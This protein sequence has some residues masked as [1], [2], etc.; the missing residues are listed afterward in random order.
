D[1]CS[2]LDGFLRGDHGFLVRVHELV[3][4]TLAA[5]EQRVNRLRNS[6]LRLLEGHRGFVGRC[7]AEVWNGMELRVHDDAV[8]TE[9]LDDVAAGRRIGQM[10]PVGTGEER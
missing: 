9:N 8:T 2:W 10:K 4:P 3:P 5:I 7:L 1:R 6:R